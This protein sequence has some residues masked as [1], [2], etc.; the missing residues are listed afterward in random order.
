MAI[1]AVRAYLG[2]WRRLC[3]LA[4]L[5]ATA[6]TVAFLRLI[7]GDEGFFLVAARLISEG[8]RPYH[9]FFFIHAPMVPYVIAV[10]F[11]LFGH[12]WYVARFAAGL[13]AVVL[14]LLIFDHL[15]RATGKAAWAAVGVLLYAGSG[16]ALGWF[17][18]S[19]TLGM[20][21]L[22]MFAGC[23]VL[24]RGG[25][26]SSLAA[27]VLLGLAASTRLYLLVSPL[28]AALFLLRAGGGARRIG[29]ELA[30]LSLGTLVGLYP[31]LLNL[32]RDH[33]ALLFGTVEYH[34]LRDVR[35]RGAIADWPQK[36]VILRSI[37]GVEGG[38]GPGSL[39][40]LGLLVGALGALV[41]RDGNRNPL[42][43][44]HWIGL[45]LVSLLPTPSYTQYFCLLVP[46]L[47]VECVTLLAAAEAPRLSPLLGV[48][49][50]AYCAL[51]W[52]DVKRYIVTGEGVAGI[53][54]PDRAPRWE[55]SLVR[56]V[57]RAV[58]EQNRPSGGSWWPGYF[59]SSRTP[60][61]I[62]L[63]NDF[64][65]VIADRVAPE[66][67]RRFHIRTHA[68]MAAMIAHHDP[69]LFVEGNWAFR[70]IADV[71]PRAGYTVAATVGPVKIWTYQSPVNG[72]LDG[73][74]GR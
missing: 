4:L 39:Q 59:V 15:R 24:S 28:C 47:I 56:Q 65:T 10:F 36:W 66:R 27:G 3:V 71:L 6:G 46:F 73:G 51:G 16:L 61:A 2:D 33:Q 22:F 25:R 55:I 32:V 12:G 13:V 30:W 74:D 14:G 21:A 52:L 54:S 62:D 9:D 38:D 49:V 5:A 64:A 50:A 72:V 43:A 40:F 70:P 35:N 53:F 31:L 48:A 34:A 17:T 45:F 58:D 60:M 69:P 8:L 37:L 7:D 26:F 68:E 42:F 29:R 23:A 41:S 11:K 67:R 19:K 44:Y 18:V 63:A 1:R 57:S 20:S